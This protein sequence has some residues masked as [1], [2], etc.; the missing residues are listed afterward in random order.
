MF[1]AKPGTNISL[2]YLAKPLNGAIALLKWLI[3]GRGPMS[4]IA[5]A[6]AAF[7]RSDDLAYVLSSSSIRLSLNFESIDITRSLQN[8]FSSTASANAPVRDCTSGPGAPDIE[9]TWGAVIS[10]DNGFKKPPPGCEGLTFV[11]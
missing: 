8:A 1:R 2:D 3:T 7:I 6:A 5:A 10:L 9:I 11:S 4:C